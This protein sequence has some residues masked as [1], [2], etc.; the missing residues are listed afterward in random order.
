MIE[1]FREHANLECHW[2]LF[3]DTIREREKTSVLTTGSRNWRKTLSSLEN[4][5][6][7]E[8]M[9]CL[10]CEKSGAIR[11]IMQTAE[12]KYSGMLLCN[13]ESSN[14]HGIPSMAPFLAK[15]SAW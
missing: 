5:G 13:N 7:M 1:L 12:T 10:G 2:Q 14:D 4:T 9:L 3:C 6:S 15:E 11:G 8:T